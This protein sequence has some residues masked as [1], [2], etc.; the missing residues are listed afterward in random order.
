M[1]DRRDDDAIN[2]VWGKERTCFKLAANSKGQRRQLSSD[3]S[4]IA[5]KVP[6]AAPAPID[7]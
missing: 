5:V 7:L 2:R 4:R 3:Q 1:L 6:E